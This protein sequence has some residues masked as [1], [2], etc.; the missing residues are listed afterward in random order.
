MWMGIG[1]F[2]T[3]PEL[4]LGTDIVG[5]LAASSAV[6][7]LAT[8]RLGKWAD[9]IGPRCA[10]VVVAGVQLF[11]IALLFITGHSFWLLAIPIVIMSVAGPMID[12][13]GRMT[14][15]GEAPAIRTRLMSLYISIM[16][17]GGGVGSWAETIAYDLG[18]WNLTSSLALGLSSLILLLSFMIWR[19]HERGEPP[20]GPA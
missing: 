19:W 20:I 2:L 7:L 18:G 1:L 4:G 17:L 14:A 13:T 5:Y 12:V 6:G 9:R 11:G 10:R 8:P 16:F 15:L 3:G